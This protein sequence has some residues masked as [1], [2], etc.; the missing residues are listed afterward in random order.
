VQVRVPKRVVLLVGLAATVAVLAVASFGGLDRAEWWSQD[1]RFKH[2]RGDKE[3]L[4]ERVRLVAI[5]DRALDTVGRWP[6]SREVFAR[7]LDEI[8]LAGAKAVAVDVTFGDVQSESSDAALAKS[9]ARTPTVVAVDMDEGQ[10]DL[11]Y[12]GG[13]EGRRALDAIVA[14]AGDDLTRPSEAIADGAKLDPARRAR[15]MERASAFKKH[16]A[17]RRIVDLRATGTPPAD[18]A[19]FVLAMT[20]GDATLRR[21]PELVL[22]REAFARDLAFGALARFMAPAKGEGS[23]LDAPPIAPVAQAAAGAGFVNSE[24]DADGQY[25]RVKPFWATPYGSLAQFGLAAGL[26]QSGIPV[27][28]VRVEPHALVFPN[29]NRIHLE[30]GELYVDWPTDIFETSVSGGAIGAGDGG[31]VVAIGALVD[32]A[33]QRQV[34][35][36]QEARYLELAADIAREQT[37][38]SSEDIKAVPVS[39]A[40]R[41]RIKEQGEFIAGDL[42]VRGTDDV[43]E[44]PEDQRRLVG[45]YREWWRLDQDLPKSRAAV[46][47]VAARLRAQ[48]EGRL[49]FVGFV[50]TGVMADMINTV[51]GPRTPGVFFHAA[52]ADMAITAVHVTLWPW[53]TGLALGALFGTACAFTAWRT[54]VGTSTVV[55]AL[56][57]AGWGWLGGHWAFGTFDVMVPVAIP[58]L[59][60]LASQAASSSTAA[61]VN[62]REKAKIKKQFQARVSP[63][64]VERLASDPDA[65]S[66]GGQLRESTIL[67]GDLAGFTTISEK[68]GS[69]A[70]VATLNLYMGAMT[71]ELTDRRAYV[72]KFLGD[73]LLAFW[74][75]FGEEPEQ[76]QLAAEACRACQKVVREIGERPERQGLPPVSLRLGVATGKVTIGDCGAPP[77]LN[78]YTVIGDSANLAARLESANK[79]FG[80]AILFDGRTRELIRDPGD[81]P[82]VPLGK[83]VVV[84]QS[85]PIDVFTMLVETPAEGWI[86]SVGTAVDA[87]R[88]GD[89][90]ACE[91]AWAAHESRFG[92]TK[93][94]RAFREALEDPEDLRD[95]VLRLRAK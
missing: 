34:L 86:E 81:L 21:F 68:L 92:K 33:E 55:M 59:A 74:S 38:L 17:W 51:Y 13:A 40:V 7:A 14:A 20:G 19:A 5:D 91:S 70:V 71:R 78:D 63:Q 24:A 35:A 61:V 69:E 28:Q 4:D 32:L 47:D 22:L 41:A 84:G 36:A 9:F 53:W 88:R 50:A 49:V 87:F 2:G 44:L 67:F 57:V 11:R 46:A 12:W 79:Q 42:E 39:D 80:T 56:I 60:A 3:P 18:E 37:D 75:A 85:T 16:V 76:G 15:F 30:D 31:G 65:L 72:N 77:D 62:A 93:I 64:L 6:W 10:L 43:A 58:A 82:I 90:A 1:F 8:H 73:G 52:V 27:D 26:L 23:A 45:A 89:F 25:R 54:G 66:M 94:A 95:G 29:G 83:V 48:F